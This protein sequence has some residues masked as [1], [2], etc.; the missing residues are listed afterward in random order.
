M[1]TI[2]WMKKYGEW[3]ECTVQFNLSFN[4]KLT[5]WILVMVIY[6]S[7]GFNGELGLI[8]LTVLS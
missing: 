7:E 3:N 6:L 4:N 8:N 1:K 5:Q 2:E